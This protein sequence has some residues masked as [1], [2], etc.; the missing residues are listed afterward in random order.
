MSSLIFLLLEFVCTNVIMFDG[1]T[2][3]QKSITGFIVLFFF[4]W[5][6]FIICIIILYSISFIHCFS[7]SNLPVI[8]SNLF[9]MS[10]AFSLLI[11][12]LFFNFYFCLKFYL[13][14]K[15]LP[16]VFHCSWRPDE[17]LVTVALNSP[18]GKLFESISIRCLVMT[19]SCSFF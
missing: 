3:F 5:F 11:Y 6:S 12:F 1:V 14:C 16:D 15:D 8:T 13:Y 19:I 4:L 17:Y 9:W 18:S 7:S 2:E 10:V